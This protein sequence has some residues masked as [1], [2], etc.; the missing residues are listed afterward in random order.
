MPA[1]EVLQDISQ[2]AGC[3]IRIELENTLD[4]MV[5]TRL[6]GGVEIARFGRRLERADDHARGVGTQVKRLPI[7]KS[8]L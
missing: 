6:V 7:E 4:N 3:G 2:L 1:L 5:G 8:G